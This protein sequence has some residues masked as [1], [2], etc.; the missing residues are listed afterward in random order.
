MTR[1][2]DNER[3]LTDVMV[4]GSDAAFHEALLGETLRLARRRRRFRQARRSVAAAAV[5]AGLAGLGV[6]VLENFSPRVVSPGLDKG[7]Y[8]MVRTV[9]L[10]A[11]AIVTTQPFAQNLLV[12]SITTA[13]VVETTPG[14]GLFREI[15]D[16][17]L[18]AMVAPKVAAIVRHGPHRA[19]LVVL[20]PADWDA[21][22]PN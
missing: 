8:T 14:S 19:E 4:D 6:L 18:L 3:L 7:H 1:R 17:E 15:S 2:T 11:T 5:L 22:P 21:T 9:P 16:D 13:N 12:A 10:P 20:E